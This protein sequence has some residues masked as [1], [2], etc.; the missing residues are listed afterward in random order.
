MGIGSY[1]ANRSVTL[2]AHAYPLGDPR[3]LTTRRATVFLDTFLLC[4]RPSHPTVL[5]PLLV[6]ASQRRQILLPEP[7]HCD[8]ALSTRSLRQ[9]RERSASRCFQSLRG[10]F[11][12]P[13]T[14]NCRSHYL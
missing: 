5:S 14:V 12:L 8:R 9:L 6:S 4:L 2:R 11:R 3:Q 7:Q 13:L 1:Q 10:S